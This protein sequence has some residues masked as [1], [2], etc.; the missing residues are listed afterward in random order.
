M[1][2]LTLLITI[3]MLFIMFATSAIFAISENAAA[4]AEINL[5]FEHPGFMG[6][7][8]QEYPFG[9]YL[10]ET[11]HYDYLEPGEIDDFVRFYWD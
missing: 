6:E 1:K 2:K 11:I 5:I 7:I 4:P 3:T 9:K 8:S 10:S